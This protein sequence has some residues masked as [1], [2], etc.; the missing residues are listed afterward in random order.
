M[1]YKVLEDPATGSVKVANDTT[2]TGIAL[3]LELRRGGYKEIMTVASD[4]GL[5]RVKELLGAE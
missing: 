1:R 3:Q 4:L 5:A 2:R